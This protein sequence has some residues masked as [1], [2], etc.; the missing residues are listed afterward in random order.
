MTDDV[1]EGREDV[2]CSPALGAELLG[3]GWSED[4]CVTLI[5]GSVLRVLRGAERVSRSAAAVRG[6][7]T[8]RI[9]DLDRP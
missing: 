5:G 6:P 9:E 2:A 1:P 7:S 4:D 8:A 3:R